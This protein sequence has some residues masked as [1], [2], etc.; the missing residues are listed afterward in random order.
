MSFKDFLQTFFPFSLIISFSVL[1]MVKVQVLNHLPF[2]RFEIFSLSFIAIG[3]L[4]KIFSTWKYSLLKC[5]SLSLI[6][7]SLYAQN[8]LHMA[9]WILSYAAKSTCRVGLVLW[10]AHAIIK[11]FTVISVS[12]FKNSTLVSI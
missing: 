2:F 11:L 3:K 4:I 5:N 10:Y 1:D 8:I 6:N 7:N 9:I 12:L